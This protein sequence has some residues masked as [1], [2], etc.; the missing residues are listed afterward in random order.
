MKTDS[1]I[2]KAVLNELKWDTHV[3]ETDVGVE[4]DGGVVT[5]TGTVSS[6]AKRIAAQKAAHR[7][8]GVL[9]V[10]D[11][12]EVNIPGSAERT[13]TEIAQ[14]VRRTLH[15]SVFVPDTR[16]TSTVSD[17]HVTL[18][19]SLD[20]IAQREEAERAVRDLTGVRGVI[21]AIKVLP[22]HTVV[23]SEVRKV[24]TDALERRL[25]GE[26]Q[27]VHVEVAGGHVTLS[28]SV[29]S[30]GERQAVVGAAK[31][32][33]GVRVIEDHLRVDSHAA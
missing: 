25:Q 29:Q 11:N 19:G 18:E 24:I 8:A 5:L 9:D 4:V 23:P 30:W 7:V 3:G 28:G 22:P 10:A 32:T 20:C 12:I 2:Q 16:I 1:E 33:P 13:D 31:G 17:G 14:A 15:W 6:W 27:R 26:L 21:N